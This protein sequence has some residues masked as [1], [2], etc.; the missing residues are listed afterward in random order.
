VL[1]VPAAIRIALASASCSQVWQITNGMKYHI[2]ELEFD[3]CRKIDASVPLDPEDAALLLDDEVQV[4]KAASGIR[5]KD[6]P[7]DKGV[8]WLV[9]TQYV[10][11]KP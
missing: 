6:R 8:A 5:K 10:S 11:P 7:T 4:K 1:N 2:A 9:K 3:C